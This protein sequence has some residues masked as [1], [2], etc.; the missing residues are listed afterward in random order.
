MYE[1]AFISRLL[2][3]PQAMPSQVKT[4]TDRTDKTGLDKKGQARN[5]H[6]N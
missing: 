4:G 1:V 5:G 6:D 2:F 3:W